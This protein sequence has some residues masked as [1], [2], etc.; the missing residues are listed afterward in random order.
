MKSKR[1]LYLNGTRKYN[2]IKIGKNIN[3]KERLLKTMI[4]LPY[5]KVKIT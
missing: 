4:V 3:I 2:K 1:F 5:S